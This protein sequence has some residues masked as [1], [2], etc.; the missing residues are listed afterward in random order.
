ML[1]DRAGYRHSR[2]RC[3][4]GCLEQTSEYLTLQDKEMSHSALLLPNQAPIIG[5]NEVVS[6]QN[7]LASG[8]WRLPKGLADAARGFP[9]MSQ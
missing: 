9:V 1:V 8:P 6:L 7:F 4:D 2:M 5:R 3:E